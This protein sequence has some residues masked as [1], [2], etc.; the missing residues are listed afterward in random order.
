MNPIVFAMRRP[1]TTMMLASGFDRRG[2][3]S[4]KMRA[5]IIPPVNTPK[6]HAYLH[7]IGTSRHAG[8]RVHRRPV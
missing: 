7:Y 1:V 5:D 2:P 8:E 3:C 6:I 4:S